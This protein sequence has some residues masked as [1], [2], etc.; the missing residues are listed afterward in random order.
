[1]DLGKLRRR[2]PTANRGLSLIEVLIVMAIAAIL[3]GIGV[4][5]MQTFIL[6]N[7]LA[8]S[9]H[10]FYTALQFARS[11][12]VRRQAQVTLVHGGAAG[13]GNWGAGWTMCVD[14]NRDNA[15][16]GEETLRAGAPLAAP[17][18]LYGNAN[19]ANFIAFDASGRLTTAGGGA[20]VICHG[21]NLVEDGQSRSRAVLVNGSG[22]V[23]L[24]L[25]ANGDGVPEK[26]SGAVASCTNP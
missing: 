24:G 14:S 22:R 9:T 21:A 15:C 17:L 10:E 18:T 7:R 8:S 26:D 25:D 13:S 5:N 12:A 3:L 20:F 16:A 19:F 2:A 4:P 23:R 11:E 1:M 6:N